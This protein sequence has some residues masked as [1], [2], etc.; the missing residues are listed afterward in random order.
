MLALRRNF[1]TL[2][3]YMTR[4]P[5]LA[6][7]GLITRLQNPFNC[8]MSLRRHEKRF[9]MLFVWFGENC[10]GLLIRISIGTEFLSR[11]SMAKVNGKL[12]SWTM[13]LGKSPNKTTVKLTSSIRS[14]CTNDFWSRSSP[15]CGWCCEIRRRLSC[16]VHQGCEPRRV[17]DDGNAFCCEWFW[18]RHID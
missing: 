12:T 16:A 7:P 14:L 11:Y 17:L 2:L 5:R 15:A 8:A 10:D 13:K 4:L 3:P 9:H 1:F 18:L 6:H